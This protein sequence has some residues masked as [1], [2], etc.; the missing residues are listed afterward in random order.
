[1]RPPPPPLFFFGVAIG[2][3]VGVGVISPGDVE[4]DEVLLSEAVDVLRGDGATNDGDDDT[5]VVGGMGERYE[6]PEKEEATDENC[7]FC[8]N[9]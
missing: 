9:V 2:V 7:D 3:G 4:V 8:V 5:G 6:D 1:M